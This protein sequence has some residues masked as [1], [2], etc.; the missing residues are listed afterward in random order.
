V[1]QVFQADSVSITVLVEN[2]VD[3]LLADTGVPGVD[4]HCITRFGLL[5][6]FDRRRKSPQAEN[7]I[8][9]LVTARSGRHHLRVLFDAGLTGT[10]LQHNLEVFGIDPNSIDHVVISHGHP[11]HFGGI[12]D[13]LRLREVSVPV[14]THHDSELPRYGMLGDG[15]VTSVYNAD[16]TAEQ[17]ERS[18]GDPVQTRSGL[19]LGLG[20]YTTGEIPRLNDFEAK[21][22]DY[23]VGS[24]G[25]YFIDRDGVI[26]TDRVMD[27]MALVIDVKNEGLVVFTGCAHAGVINTITQARSICGPR[28]V[29]A[30]MG[31]FHLGFP[32][33]PPEHVGLTADAFAEL[34]V[35]SV[36]PMHCSGLRAHAH[37]SD[38]LSDRYIQPSVGATLY[39]G[40]PA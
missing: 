1:V 6:H 40:S 12:H 29:R 26:Q 14:A 5:E 15:R 17:L 10:V 23:E 4:D 30:V 11:D 25:A 27:E 38:V 39:I 24:P 32:S 3:M 35:R 33:T 31:G 18:G 20:V 2:W 28:P 21:I 16:F 7:G 8:S 36:M 9:L 37:F 13:F 19:D 22:P 34:D